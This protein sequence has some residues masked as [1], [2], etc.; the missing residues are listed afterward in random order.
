MKTKIS[1]LISGNPFYFGC[2]FLI[3]GVSALGYKISK[4]KSFNMDDYNIAGWEALISSW[5]LIILSLIFG[6]FLILK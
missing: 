5:G 4:K 1:E 3:I 6:I 2:L